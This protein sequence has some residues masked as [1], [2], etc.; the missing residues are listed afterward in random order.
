[1]QNN[2]KIRLEA[3]FRFLYLNSDDASTTQNERMT[4]SIHNW[5]ECERI[6]R[7]AQTLFML[8][9]HECSPN[10]GT[11]VYMGLYASEREIEKC[12]KIITY[13]KRVSTTRWN[14]S[15]VD[16]G[17]QFHFIFLFTEKK[18]FLNNRQLKM[19]PTKWIKLVF[20]SKK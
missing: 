5:N 16:G 13:V 9:P 4:S 17:Q 7:Y 3:V 1:M 18:R 6:V 19:Y 10:I 15:A 2:G 12:W 14:K 11:S 20:D 8:Q